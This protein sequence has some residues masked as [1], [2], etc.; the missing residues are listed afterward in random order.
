MQVR[1]LDAAYNAAAAATKAANERAESVRRE[2]WA[3]DS[4]I[5]ALQAQI[6]EIKQAGRSKLAAFGGQAVQA[7]VAVVKRAEREF[8]RPPIGPVGQHLALEDSRSGLEGL[9]V[10]LNGRGG[11]RRLLR[12]LH[13]VVLA[14]SSGGQHVGGV[15]SS[16]GRVESGWWEKGKGAG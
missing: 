9:G 15:K 8:S 13:A 6:R 11:V 4:A 14:T 5:K 10:K 12:R 7:L 16:C 3:V 2:I 1:G